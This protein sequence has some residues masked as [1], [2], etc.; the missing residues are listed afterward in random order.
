[1]NK[2]L[3]Y[4]L[5]YYLPHKWGVETVFEQIIARSL[6][7]WYH[8]IVLTSHYDSSLP[9]YEDLWNLEIYRV[10]TS[11]K[12][13]IWKWFLEGKHILKNHPDILWIHTSTYW[14]AIP[15]S[16]LGKIYN[17][18]VLLTVHE[19]FWKL[20]KRYKTRWSAR[21]YIIFEWIIF[22]L[23]F[24]SY[25]CVSCYT[26]NSLRIYFWIPD[27]KLFLAYNGVDYDF[28]NKKKVTGK[29]IQE[30][31]GKFHL[32][33]KWSLLYFGHTGISKG[34]DTLIEAVPSILKLDEDIQ[35]IFNFIPANRDQY[36]KDKL[37]TILS[38]L[39]KQD[40][41][42]V[43]VWNWLSKQELRAL[44]SQVDGVIAPS[45][46]EGF[47]SVHTETLALW[48]PLITTHVSALP[49]VV[50]WNVLFFS[51][52]NIDSLCTAIQNLK[53]WK[54]QKLPEKRFSWDEQFEKIYHRYL[55]L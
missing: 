1:M 25:H 19:I 36:I 37:T 30:I 23:P 28:W 43:Q 15:A 24:D 50:W 44:V 14:G 18:K 40:Q 33:D 49:E 45:L 38:S 4:I 11:R 22:H 10:W 29:E 42:R 16:L 12:T 6:S 31:Q 48:T 51:P 52:K 3:L 9:Q 41:K 34:I 17:K 35:L 8:C 13:F 2:T 55:S 20:W 32:K 53:S 7:H 26:L 39:S 21:I 5:D 54:F 47:W 27:G 46:S